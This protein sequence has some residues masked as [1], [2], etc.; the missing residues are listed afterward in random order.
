MIFF[1]LVARTALRFVT[2][3]SLV[4]PFS[5]FPGVFFL[6]SSLKEKHKND[7]M[8]LSSSISVSSLPL[9]S[10]SSLVYPVLSSASS[11]RRIPR[12]ATATNLTTTTT[13]TPIT[14]A[15]QSIMLSSA[16]T[17]STSTSSSSSSASCG[18]TVPFSSI[19]RIPSNVVSSSYSS[20]SVSSSSITASS[21]DGKRVLKNKRLAEEAFVPDTLDIILPTLLDSS[22]KSECRQK[23][24]RFTCL[25]ETYDPKSEPRGD[26]DGVD[27]SAYCEKT[28]RRTKPRMADTFVVTSP[29]NV[30]ISPNSWYTEKKIYTPPS[31][32]SVV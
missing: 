32:K 11:R 25:Q 29:R 24:G 5:F 16:C 2:V 27:N 13:P 23:I 26:A 30:T 7:Y 1:F 19:A 17:P 8:S 3:C 18:T 14:T 15:T 4:P 12:K 20:S 9:S 6:S 10:S 21:V 28:G 22:A 31:R